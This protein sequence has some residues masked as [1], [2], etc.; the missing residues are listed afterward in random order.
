MDNLVH[1]CTAEYNN[2]S[3]CPQDRGVIVLTIVTN[4]YEMIVLLLSPLAFVI[5]SSFDLFC[6]C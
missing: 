2:A 3:G 6:L 5:F 4:R 1:C